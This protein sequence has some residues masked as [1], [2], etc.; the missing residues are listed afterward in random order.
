MNNQP[1]TTKQD[2]QDEK[3]LWKSNSGNVYIHCDDLEAVASLQ[4]PESQLKEG[5]T[6][7]E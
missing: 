5:D 1:D 6:E 3:W 7:N 4:P 2:T